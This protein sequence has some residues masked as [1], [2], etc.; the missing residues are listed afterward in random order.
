MTSSQP[1]V[2]PAIAALVADEL[3]NTFGAWLICAS[4]GCM[5]FG[6]TTHQT[7]R[8]FR[9]YPEDGPKLKLLVFALLILDTLHTVTN[10]HLCYYYLVINYLKPSALGSGV[11]SL[12]ISITET[13]LVML[14]SHGFFLRRIF[15]LGERK[16]LPVLIIGI[17]MVSELAFAIAVT[18]M[19]FVLVS[20]EAFKTHMWMI[21]VML[22]NAVVID[23]L[24]T[25]CLIFYLW[26]SRTGFKRT[27]NL[28]DVLM[29]YTINTGLSTSLLTLPAM[30][31]AI[32]MPDNLI[33]SAIY[34]IASKMYANSLLAVLNSRRSLIDKGMEGFETGSFGLQVMDPRELR[35][36]DFKTPLHSPAAPPM[37]AAGANTPSNLKVVDTVIDI[38]V[39]TETFVD[40]P[41]SHHGHGLGRGRNEDGAA[42]LPDDDRSDD[43]DSL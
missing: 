33:W 28:L 12:R 25:N 7:Y 39:T 17:L 8:Y 1:L 35:P 13:A 16:I 5:L 21:W 23:L 22:A 36:L 43:R 38:K 3:P 18:V 11:W 14:V 37:S 4:V 2:P 26:R 27:D 41:A 24:V 42:R 19:T 30:I 6:L 20:F 29:V 34:V 31:C 10:I 32:I 9:L 15:L 40:I